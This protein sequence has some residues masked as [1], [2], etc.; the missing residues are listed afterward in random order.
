MTV[1]HDKGASDQVAAMCAVA[2]HHGIDL[3]L[4]QG[5]L[6]DMLRATEEA[7][8]G[9]S[10]FT[11][12]LKHYTDTASAE[13]HDIALRSSWA[14]AAVTQHP[15][16]FRQPPN[17]RHWTAIAQHAD[18]HGEESAVAVLRALDVNRQEVLS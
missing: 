10:V 12:T 13:I 9:L 15:K 17:S 14:V 1:L 18:T 5:W 11:V 16:M 7:R 2:A 3:N 6:N 8:D 4:Q